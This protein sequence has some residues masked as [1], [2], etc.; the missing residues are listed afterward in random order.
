M[1]RKPLC[2]VRNGERNNIETM[3][4]PLLY[5]S[6]SGHKGLTSD[7]VEQVKKFIISN[8][9]RGMQVDQK[10][11]EAVKM[12]SQSLELSAK[13]GFDQLKNAIILAN[14]CFEEWGLIDSQ[15]YEEIKLL[16]SLG[17]EAVKPTGS[18]RGGYLLSLWRNPPRSTANKEFIPLN[19][20]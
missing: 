19:V 17:A 5:L 15:M 11:R 8:P 18:G 13:S 20:Y 4:N 14:S 6:Y 12:S 10:M 2:F 3:W 7:C 16:K 1:S 9:D